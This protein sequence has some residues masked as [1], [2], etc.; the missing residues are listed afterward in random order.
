MTIKAKIWKESRK[1]STLTVILPYPDQ[2][3]HTVIVYPVSRKT[4]YTRPSR[5]NFADFSILDYQWYLCQLPQ[6]AANHYINYNISEL[7]D[8]EITPTMSNAGAL[9]T[10]ES[11]K[12]SFSGNLITEEVSNVMDYFGYFV[13]FLELFKKASSFRFRVLV[14]SISR[15]MFSILGR[16]VVWKPTNALI[17]SSFCLENKD[18]SRN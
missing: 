4:L 10:L 3:Q 6:R 14:T 5:W 18:K 15:S 11:F 8:F 1:Y 16:H 2:S 17:S 12:I 13:H 9:L 7:C